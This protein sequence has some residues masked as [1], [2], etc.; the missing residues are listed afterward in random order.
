MDLQLKNKRALVTGSTQ[1]IGYAIAKLL[2]TE[3]A[4]VI[5]N[6]RSEQSVSRAENSL[7]KSVPNAKITGMPCDF[8]NAEEV[9]RFIKDV[10]EVDILV[11]NVGIFTNKDFFNIPDEDWE[12]LYEVNVMSGVRL[13]RAFLPKMLNNDWGRI[14]F[15]SSESAVN[16]PVE[17]IH[18]GVS[19]TA[20]LGLSRGIAEMT[21]GTGVTV[22]A[23]L[24]GPTLT[25]GIKEMTGINDG[26]SKKEV[27]KHFFN[28]ERPTSIIQRFAEPEEVANLVAYVASPL[29]SATNGASLRV[30]GGVVKTIY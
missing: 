13:S 1:G 14:I 18:Y 5:I 9:G 29:S 4:S 25:A 10:G 20:V 6:G 28:K 8:A 11:N 22:N 15:I 27:E 16:I 7:K 19:K 17:M 30:D 3:G 24:P 2:A 26:K 23:I 12:K 21:K